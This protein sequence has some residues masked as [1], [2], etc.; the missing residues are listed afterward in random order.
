LKY[1]VQYKFDNTP[2]YV[3]TDDYDPLP[4]SPAVQL[5][6]DRDGPP[7]SVRVFHV[8]GTR[9]RDWSELDAQHLTSR[10]L[11]TLHVKRLQSYARKTH[12]T[13]DIAMNYSPT[14][15]LLISLQKERRKASRRA[16]RALKKLVR[17]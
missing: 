3:Y 2:F 7:D 15:R 10:F 16:V 12:R 9:R 11:K 17:S 14:A 4:V 6:I 8:R 13:I 1:A 5:I